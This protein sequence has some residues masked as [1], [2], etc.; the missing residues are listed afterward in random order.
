MNN[1]NKKAV[2][3]RIKNI[4]QDL[5][6]SMEEFGEILSTSKGAV[7][8]WEKGKNLPNNWR[9]KKIA[10]LG[11][12]SLDSLLYE[13]LLR[14]ILKMMNEFENYP[15]VYEVSKANFISQGKDIREKNLLSHIYD[16][17]NYLKQPSTRT[18]SPD[19][20]SID[21]E[22][23]TADRDHTARDFYKTDIAERKS[24]ILFTVSDIAENA[25]IRPYEQERIASLLA[26]EA[27]SLYFGFSP[28]KNGLLTLVKT[29]LKS[30]KEEVDIFTNIHSV[31]AEQNTVKNLDAEIIQKL[32]SL[33]E[34]LI[35]DIENLEEK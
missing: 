27:E 23:R 2:G 32:D 29:R 14:T 34:S 31:T 33:I 11:N 22:G 12:I 6:M 10:K 3:A 15:G 20:T 9:L 5:G 19:E 4:R 26:R 25:G 30:L 24:K 28:D 35:N 8:N 16:Y 7:N 17:A 18:P 1:I 13:R 21:Y